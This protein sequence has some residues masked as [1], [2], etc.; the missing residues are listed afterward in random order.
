MVLLLLDGNSAIGAQVYRKFGNFIYLRQL[1]ISQAVANLKRYK[2]NP[3]IFFMHAQRVL[4]YHLITVQWLI[5]GIRRWINTRGVYRMSKNS[6]PKGLVHFYTVN[7]YIK[8]DKSSRT[9]TTN[10]MKISP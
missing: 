7:H 2:K 8:M 10:C 3:K 5:M 4:S 1:L 6:C 9:H